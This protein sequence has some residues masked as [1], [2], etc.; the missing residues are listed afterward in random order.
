MS[1]LPYSPGSGLK[2]FF[3]PECLNCGRFHVATDLDGNIKEL[4]CDWC[5]HVVKPGDIKSADSKE[6]DETIKTLQ[7]FVAA[8][9]DYDEQQAKGANF[10]DYIKKVRAC[11]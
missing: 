9:D 4:V 11:Y 7:A 1:I 8:T 10:T 3:C 6:H 5:E 2:L